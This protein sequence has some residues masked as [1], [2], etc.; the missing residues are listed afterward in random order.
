[1]E[2]LLTIRDLTV[3]RSDDGI[4]LSIGAPHGFK[5]ETLS[6]SE[7]LHLL[8]VIRSFILDLPPAFQPPALVP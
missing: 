1:M 8:S 4:Q 3:T 2:A 5:S 7:A 6:E